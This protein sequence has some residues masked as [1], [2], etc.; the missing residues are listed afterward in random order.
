[1][2]F[3]ISGFVLALPFATRFLAGGPRVSLGAYYLRRLTRLEPPY[4]IA[5]VAFFA[6]L[7]VRAAHT[8]GEL[9]PHLLA[10]LAY[11]HNLV[12]GQGSL[13][14]VVAWS[15]EIEVQFYL[16][17]PVLCGVFA[18]RSRWLRRAAIVAAAVVVGLVQWKFIGHGTRAGLTLLNFAQ[19]FFAGFLL[20]DLYL[21]E[22]RQQ[23]ST[24]RAWDLVG[25]AACVMM[26][27]S[28]QHA[29]TE[30]VIFPFAALVA[31]MA[32]FRGPMFRRGLTN[33]WI[34]SIGGMCY[35]IYLLHYPFI[36]AAG[37]RTV[38]LG[39]TADFGVNLFLQ[40]LLLIP[41]LLVV[42][43]LYFVFIERP[44][45][46]RDWP[47]RLARNVAAVR[48]QTFLRWFLRLSP[49]RPRSPRAPEQQNES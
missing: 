46:E 10:S 15:L 22:W 35:T 17:A 33:P 20:A 1:L 14:N 21:V 6:I 31:Y 27:F 47:Q 12:Y 11:V 18:I 3:I 40:T 25:L 5:M 41:P 45:M 42:S 29:V 43:S 44:C 9:G 37:A 19:F 38:S 39:L 32:A 26:V 24:R 8:V 16:L 49:A 2:F 13:L 28:W 30:R 7:A 36:S 23:P 48:Q 4:I 34:T